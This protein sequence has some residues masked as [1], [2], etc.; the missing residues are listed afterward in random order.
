MP[1]KVPGVRQNRDDQARSE[2]THA[3][4]RRSLD[5][6]RHKVTDKA[7]GNRPA[8]QVETII[9]GKMVKSV[10][11]AG[12]CASRRPDKHGNNTTL[13]PDSTF[14]FR[15][16]TENFDIAVYETTTVESSRNDPK[17]VAQ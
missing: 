4:Q 17:V 9:I 10:R 14:A 11:N 16:L 2:V 8:R 6:M 5:Y 7:V 3:Q 15:G 12:G 1:E 13:W